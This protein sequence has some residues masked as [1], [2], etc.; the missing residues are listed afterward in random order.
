MFSVLYGNV[1]MLASHQLE[2]LRPPLAT[3]WQ[4]WSMPG[5]SP[6]SFASEEEPIEGL[7]DDALSRRFR[8]WR[9]KSGNGYVFSVFDASKCPP[10][11]DAVLIAAAVEP[12]G[13]RRP[14]AVEDTGPF[15]EPLLSRLAAA[16][17][18]AE[19][20]LEFHIHLLA[21]TPAERRQIVEDL[22]AAS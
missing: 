12:D 19:R 20:R 13:T 17:L 16:E 2:A 5:A 14:L 10:Y 7:H 3:N 11:G 22:R 21:R 6:V 8:R 4:S 18:A 1:P 9:G 15:P